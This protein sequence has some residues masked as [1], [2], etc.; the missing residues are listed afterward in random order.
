MSSHSLPAATDFCSPGCINSW[1]GDRY[2]DTS[3]R[4]PDCG[5]DAGDCGT[6]RWDELLNY[7]VPYVCV[8]VCVCMY[9]RA[10]DVCK[11]NAK[12]VVPKQGEVFEILVSYRSLFAIF[13]F[14]LPQ[15]GE[16]KNSREG[17]FCSATVTPFHSRFLRMGHILFYLL[18][19]RRFTST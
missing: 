13:K 5:Y 10:S 11:H 7:Q 19:Q 18:V 15:P 6:D 3:C 1:L 4:V 9:V 14:P 16:T 8:C 17:G 12:A 2:C